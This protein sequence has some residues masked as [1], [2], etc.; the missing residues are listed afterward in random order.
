MYCRRSLVP[1]ASAIAAVTPT[2]VAISFPADKTTSSTSQ[3]VRPV[4]SPSAFRPPSPAPRFNGFT[5]TPLES[6]LSTSRKHVPINTSS[7]TRTRV[8]VQYGLPRNLPPAPRPIASS[9]TTTTLDF[10]SMRNNYLTMLAHK[11]NPD[12]PASVPTTVTP[13]A[14]VSAEAAQAK[15]FK[16]IAEL[17]APHSTSPRTCSADESPFL[18]SP[19]ESMLDDFGTSPLDTPFS[20]FLS[21]PMMGMDDNFMESPLIRAEDNA[22]A[23][24]LFA[25]TD[26]VPDFPVQ[27]PSAPK[28]NK[29]FTHSPSTPMLESMDSPS[30]ARVPRRRN[31]TGTRKNLTPDSLISLDAP[32]QKRVYTAPSV[33]SRKVLPAGFVR[34]RGFSTA[35]GIDDIDEVLPELSPTASEQ[36]QIE[37]KRRQN[38]LAAR[39]SRKRKLEHQQGLEGQ[40]DDLKRDVTMWRERALMAQEM[41]RS[42]GIKFNFDAMDGA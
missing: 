20:D 23:G 8:S 38:T 39:K 36:E 34:K 25:F 7:S 6:T 4:N 31:V 17:T 37:Y 15:A 9:T 24:P 41:L 40:L 14:L 5:N 13:A 12:T 32:T 26:D 29:L 18:T 21:T 16:A 22:F 19:H 2:P 30:P 35:F 10:A 27:A 3:D 28:T 1:S 33:T 42:A 11:S